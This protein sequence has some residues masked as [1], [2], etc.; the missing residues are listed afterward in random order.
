MSTPWAS[1][2]PVGGKGRQTFRNQ[3]LVIFA[4]DFYWLLTAS[5]LDGSLCSPKMK[6]KGKVLPATECGSDVGQMN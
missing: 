3:S 2:V 4:N 1:L 6:V 5:T